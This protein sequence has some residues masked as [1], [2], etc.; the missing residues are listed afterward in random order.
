MIRQFVECLFLEFVWYFSQD[1]NGFMDFC[2]GRQDGYY[3]F[4]VTSYQEY[5]L[6]ILCIFVNAGLDRLAEVVFVRFLYR[7]LYS[8]LPFLYGIL[9]GK[10]NVGNLYWMSENWCSISLRM[11]Y[12]Y[13][14]FGILHRRFMDLYPCIYV[15]NYLLIPIWSYGNLFYTLGCNPILLSVFYCSSHSSFC[16]GELF[17]LT[18]MS[19]WHPLDIVCFLLFDFFL[20]IFLIPGTTKNIIDLSCIFP[21]PVLESAIYTWNPGSLLWKIVLE[22]KMWVVSVS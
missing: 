9:W 13:K 5:R 17:Q 21:A 20:R 18:Y 10:V 6:S 7:K 2:R 14:L 11:K 4:F 19:L 22:T 15:C 1:Y 8:F 16:H 3:A 12:L